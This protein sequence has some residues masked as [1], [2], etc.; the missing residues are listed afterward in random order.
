VTIDM[1]GLDSV[2]LIGEN[3]N[4]NGNEERIVSVGAGADW[5]HVYKYLDA[6]NL[7]AAG[8]RNGAVGVAG[9]LTGGGISYFS[10]RTGWACDGIEGVEVCGFSS[11]SAFPVPF[12]DGTTASISG[13]RVAGLMYHIKDCACKWISHHR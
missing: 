3:K 5:L 2:Q 4:K 12:W 10:P 1:S 6:F 8:G 9:L 7:S 13:L 11:F